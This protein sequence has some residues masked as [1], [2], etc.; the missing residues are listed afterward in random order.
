MEALLGKS[1]LE[2]SGHCPTAA[3]FRCAW[4]AVHAGGKSVTTGLIQVDADGYSA[5]RQKTQK[6]NWRK[7]YSKA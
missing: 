7:H 2:L 6:I 3:Q 1:D 5:G 4:D